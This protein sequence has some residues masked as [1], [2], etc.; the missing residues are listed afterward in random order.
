MSISSKE[1][2]HITTSAVPKQGWIDRLFDNKKH[3]EILSEYAD[4]TLA[5][6]QKNEGRIPELTREK[7]RKLYRKLLLTV[8]PITFLVNATLFIDKDAIGYSSLLGVFEDLH[9]GTPQ[10]NNVLTIFVCGYIAGSLPSHLLFQRIPMSKYITIATA[11]WSLLCFCMLASKSFSGFAAIRFFLGFVE[12]GV[13]PAIQHTLAMFFTLEEQAIVNPIFWISCL[14]VGVPMGFV[15]YGLQY[16]TAWRPWKWYYLL[17]GIL[18]ALVSLFCYFY[19]PDN[20]ANYKVFTEEER[21]HIIDRIKKKSNSSIEEK[22][23]KKY[24]AIEA[25]RDPV[26]WCFFFFAL[27]LMFE[28]SVTYQASIIYTQLGYKHLLTTLLMVV[29]TGV[30]TVSAILGSLA[31]HKWRSQSC[32]VGA[33]F[34]VPSLLGGLLAICAPWSKKY[35]IIAGVYLTRTTGTTYIIGLSLSQASAAGYT[36]R[37]MRTLM[38]TIGYCCANLISPQ[39]FLDKDKPRYKTAWACM[40]V[41]SWILAPTMLLV[42]RFVLANRN[43]KRIALWEKDKLEGNTEREYGYIDHV[44]ESGVISKEKVPV[45]MLDITDLENERFIYPL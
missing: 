35:A 11:C 45:S 40:I 5:F 12:A 13:T 34:I 17:I 19:Y 9:M 15:S 30:A 33:A 10:Y 2:V 38:F 6:V 1:N 32:L 3:T 31:L 25:L 14:G 39:L 22:R 43:K 8:L 37:I 36:K 26:S 42:I 16:T 21:F 24:Q 28:N 18:S 7:E 4:V 27:F 23:F 29:M 44:D 41:F 20:P